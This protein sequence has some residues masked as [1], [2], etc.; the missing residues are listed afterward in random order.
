MHPME[1]HTTL[2]MR[3]NHPIN[4]SDGNFSMRSSKLETI[5]SGVP[6]DQSIQSDVFLWFY[7]YQQSFN[8]AYCTHTHI[9]SQTGGEVVYYWFNEINRCVVVVFNG[10]FFWFSDTP[11]CSTVQSLMTNMIG[12]AISHDKYKYV[13]VEMSMMSLLDV[14]FILFISLFQFLYLS[15]ISLW[16]KCV[17]NTMS[18][19]MQPYHTYSLLLCKHPLTI[20]LSD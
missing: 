12:N 14:W 4:C 19:M 2:K 16:K 8:Y 11:K 20:Y 10:C 6:S 9:C 15:F 17:K 18:L 7:I 13:K 3:S 1:C 5:K